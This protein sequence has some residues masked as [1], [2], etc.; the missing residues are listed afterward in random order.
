M[1]SS[2]M[3]RRYIEEAQG[4]IELVRLA[5]TRQLWATVVREAQEC[6]ELFLKGALRLV[7]VEPARTHD[8]AELFRRERAR[9]PDWFRV[10]AERLASIST[11]MAADRGPALYGDERQGVGPQDLFDESAAH[12]AVRKL[13]EVAALCGQLLETVSSSVRPAN[14]MPDGAEPDSDSRAESHTPDRKLE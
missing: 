4:R 8:V 12:A 11:D 13:E 14:A 2:N 3:G 10:H 9:F 5:L 7:A 1:T 6:V